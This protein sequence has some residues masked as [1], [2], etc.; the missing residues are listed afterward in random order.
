MLLDA[1]L[2]RLEAIAL[3]DFLADTGQ[4]M[5]HSALR[6]HFLFGLQIVFDLDAREVIRDRLAVSISGTLAL[7]RL[8]STSLRPSGVTPIAKYTALLRTVPSSRIFTRSASKNT[9]AYSGSS[10]R[11]C[12]ESSIGQVE[13]EA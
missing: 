11:L 6:A 7:V 12:Q 13:M 1:D 3:A 10:G 2:R 4:G 9:N 5:R 8:P